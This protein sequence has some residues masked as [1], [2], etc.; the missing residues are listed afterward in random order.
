MGTYLFD[1]ID[2]LTWHSNG[3]FQEDLYDSVKLFENCLSDD[4]PV[5]NDHILYSLNNHSSELLKEAANRLSHS[6]HPLDN[7]YKMTM[8]AI[9]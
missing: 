7:A 2:K 3:S 8:M 4:F 9:E 1:L 6:Y 5:Q